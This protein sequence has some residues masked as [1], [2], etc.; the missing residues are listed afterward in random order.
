MIEFK[1]STERILKQALND[2]QEKIAKAA[3]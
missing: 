1:K 3:S 2:W